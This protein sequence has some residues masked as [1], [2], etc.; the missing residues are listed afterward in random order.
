MPFDERYKLIKDAGFDSVM[1]WW[2]DK[3]GRGNGYQE[4]VKFARN[5]GLY[6]ENI[7]TPVHEQNCLSSNTTEGENVYQTYLRCVENCYENEISTMV[8]HLPNDKFPINNLGI[9]RL[10]KIINEWSYV[11]I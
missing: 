6:I 9:N 2:S 4:D 8:V 1:L 5:A 10:E 3:F 7:H 11:K